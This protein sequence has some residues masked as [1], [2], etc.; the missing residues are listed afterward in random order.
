[1]GISGEF[2]SGTHSDRNFDYNSFFDFLLKGQDAYERVPTERFNIDGWK[3]SH[4]GQ[5]HTDTGCF[6]KGIDLFDY[7]EFGISL[8]DAQ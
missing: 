1:V 7:L 6:L 2:P 5:V 4:L 8:K 3:G